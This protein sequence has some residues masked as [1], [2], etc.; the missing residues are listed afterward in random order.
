VEKYC[1]AGQATD[2]NITRRVRFAFWIPT[3]TDT[4]SEYVIPIA[5]PQQQLLRGAPQRS[6]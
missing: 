4:H 6:V 3:A 2:D 5:F 1:K